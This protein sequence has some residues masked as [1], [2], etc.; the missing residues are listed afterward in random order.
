MPSSIS[1]AI[2]LILRKSIE[3]QNDAAEQVLTDIFPFPLGIDV[4]LQNL[5]LFSQLDVDGLH[6]FLQYFFCFIFF[7]L[8]LKLTPNNKPV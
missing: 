5:N 8:C 7:Y 3:I 6:Y 4:A 1:Q 2:Q